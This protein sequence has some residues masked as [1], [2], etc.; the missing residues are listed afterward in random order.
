MFKYMKIRVLKAI[1]KHLELVTYTKNCYIIRE[2]EPL[3]NVIFITQGTALSYKT[4]NNVNIGGT[5]SNSSIIKCLKKD[6]FFGDEL[7]DWAFVFASISDL[8]VSPK[9]VMSQTR[10]EAFAI[11]ASN[12]RRVVSKFRLHFILNLPDLKHS[13]LER[14]AATSLQTAWRERENHSSGW[15]KLKELLN[16]SSES[17]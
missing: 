1:V 3:W 2:G 14:M 9:T 10:V 15:N 11:N 17:D 4:S 12:L 16:Y 8:P 7:L 5:V 6:D 13:P